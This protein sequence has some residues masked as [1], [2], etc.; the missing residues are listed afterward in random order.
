MK[1]NSLIKIAKLPMATIGRRG[2]QTTASRS[3]SM[4]EKYKNDKKFLETYDPTN[5]SIPVVQGTMELGMEPYG[6]YKTAYAA[7]KRAGNIA[8]IRGAVCLALTL[9]LFY[10]SG[11][12]DGFLMPNLDNVMEDTV[13][14]E[15]DQEGRMSVLNPDSPKKS[16]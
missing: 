2:L 15:F 6:S 12:C 9:T 10:N 16:D 14:F 1:M 13:P 8:I 11:I 7:E 4:L 3:S 5:Y